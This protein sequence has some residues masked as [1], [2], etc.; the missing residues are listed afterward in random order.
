MTHKTL[1][2]FEYFIL[3]KPKTT[4]AAIVLII[5][6]FSFFTTEFRLD[7]SADT[8]VLENDQSLQYYRSIRARYGSDDFLI[9]TY[10][11]R[12]DLFI[13]GSLR[14]L[15]Q[16]QDELNRVEGIE[17]VTSILNVPLI[18]SPLTTLEKLRHEVQTLGSG[19]VDKRLAQ[20]EFLSSP[21]YRELLLS[22]DS[23]TTA[24]LLNIKRDKRY[25]Q[26]LHQRDKVF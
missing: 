23:Q 20:K 3:G 26:L 11:P 6:F 13:D 17:N 21:I 16:L 18:A 14:R 2:Y 8:L 22:A 12:E 25:F 19:N 9:V 5:G 15:Q 10:S 1:E 4:L 24:L 7:A